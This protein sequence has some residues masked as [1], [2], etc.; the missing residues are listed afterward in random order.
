MKTSILAL[1]VVTMAA[2]TN[3][4]IAE[5]NRTCKAGGET[6]A[7]GN[8]WACCSYQCDSNNK[9]RDC[10]AIDE[11]CMSDAQCCI[12]VCDQ[13]TG[14]CAACVPEGI[15]CSAIRETPFTCCRDQDSNA[16][17][18]NKKNGPTICQSC[19]ISNM[20]KEHC[21]E[22]E[23]CCS[24]CC[25]KAWLARKGQCMVADECDHFRNDSNWSC[26]NS[27]MPHEHCYE[28]EECC[29]GCCKKAWLAKKGQCMVADECDH[30]GVDNLNQ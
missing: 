22:N 11:R 14:K 13:G 21:Y 18:F 26:L 6:C 9:C 20:P 17:C 23:E 2:L 15:E 27:N 12:G 10:L 8:D 4:F 25:K 28:N 30:H 24:G 5:S 29:S 16:R 7:P 3:G 19:G 1:A